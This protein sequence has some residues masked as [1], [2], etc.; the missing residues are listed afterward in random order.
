[1]SE[2]A[3]LIELPSKETALATYSADKGLEPFL[4]KIRAEIDVFVPDVSTKKGRDAVASIAHKVAK[5]KVALDNIGK[6]LVAN[7]KDLPR[8]VDAER[9]RMRDTLDAWKDEVRQPLTCWEQAEESRIAAHKAHLTEMESCAA[10]LDGRTAD[11]LESAISLI[12]EYTINDSWEE[13]EAEAAHTKDAALSKLRTALTARQKYEA[14]QAE[15]ARLRA[16]SAER[17]RK[18]REARIAQEAA[19]KAKREA[20]AKAKAERDAVAKRQ[21]DAKAASERRELELKLKAEKA[22]RERLEAIQKAEREKTEAVEAERQRQVDEA[23]RVAAETKKR[24]A[25][26]THKAKINAAALNA[27]IVGGLTP[28]CAKL[29]VTLIAKKTIPAITINY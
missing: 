12:E 6:E 22:E 4:A 3:E 21:A 5:S 28:E 19:D 1:M 7:L 15:L 11:E 26:R 18:D 8:K 17:D 13:F 25:D 10:S 24:E 14:E 9:K 20:E 29:A 16:E 2:I 27:F 23:A